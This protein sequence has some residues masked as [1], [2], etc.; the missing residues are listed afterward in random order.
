[1]KVSLHLFSLLA[2]LCCVPLS[3]LVADPIDLSKGYSQFP[4]GAS[5]DTLFLAAQKAYGADNV[6]RNDCRIDGYP[7]EEITV[8]LRDGST[9]FSFF[10]DSFYRVVRINSP[11]IT[12]YY[13]EKD[14]SSAGLASHAKE[15]FST[16]EGIEVDAHY[17]ITGQSG[18]RVTGVQLIVGITN[19]A[20]YNEKIQELRAAS[21]DIG[22]FLIDA[23]RKP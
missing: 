21:P 2:L 13:N 4:W 11:R 5:P 12:G 1:M 16:N 8:K 10:Q 17:K 15:L 23:F 3:S 9:I 14:L 18:D 6:T 7:E 20:L 22:P 19:H